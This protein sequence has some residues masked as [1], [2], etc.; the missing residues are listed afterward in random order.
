[1][2]RRAR[3]LA[4]SPAWI[5]PITRTSFQN[6]QPPSPIATMQTE[7]RGE[8][9]GD[10]QRERGD[11]DLE[12]EQRLEAEHRPVAPRGTCPR[13]ASAS[14]TAIR[15]A[16]GSEPPWRLRSCTV[17][18]PTSTRD[19]Q[20]QRRPRSPR[21]ARGGRSPGAERLERRARGLLARAARRPRVRSSGR[22]RL[23]AGLV[24]RAGCACR[25]SRRARPRRAARA[26]RAPPPR[27]SAASAI[28]RST[29]HAPGAG[30]RCTSP[31][32]AASSPPIAKNGT[33][34]WAAA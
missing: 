16:P 25:S 18:A 24:G 15:I 31:M 6:S 2:P 4:P 28:A 26:A 14:T 12:R 3:R 5:R 11:D 1:M 13:R 19:G 33:R 29:T 30:L 8:R 17:S 21:A 27:G 7:R 20:Q 34:A 9:R 23:L 22:G 10:H 32:L